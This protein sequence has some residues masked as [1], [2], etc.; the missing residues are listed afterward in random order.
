MKL[1]IGSHVS[2]KKE[3][4]L[5]GSIKEALSYGAN[6]FMIYTGAPQ[7]T[8]RVAINKELVVAGQELLKAENIN[9][10]HI[11]V[12]APYII[13]VANN[14]GDNNAFAIAFLK[15]E[16]SRVKE[17][18]LKY[19]VL[20]PGSFVKLTRETGLDN[21]VNALNEALT[22]ELGITILLETMAGKGTE[23][24]INFKELKYIIERIKHQSLIGVCLDTCHMHDGGYNLDEFDNI[25]LE[26]DQMIGIDKIKCI[27]LNDSKNERGAH[28]DRHENFGLGHIGF[29]TLLNIIYHPK[30]TD[31]PKILETPYIKTEHTSYPPYKFEIDMIKKKVFN[32]NLINDI[33][34][35]YE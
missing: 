25:L 14:V 2:F 21:I 11:V 33:V 12:H 23:I 20:H 16:M 31:V 19:L 1:I 8:N 3:E 15:Q 18:G 30:L 10:D 35:Y 26:F 5:V 24:G 13:N 6:T 9:P 7:N 32:N 22:P 29:D 17:L 28:K 34:S 27:H 4:Q